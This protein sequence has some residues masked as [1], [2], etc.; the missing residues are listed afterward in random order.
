MFLKPLAAA[1]RQTHNALMGIAT[2]LIA[3]GMADA[4]AHMGVLV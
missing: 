4:V 3:Y 2:V 1:A